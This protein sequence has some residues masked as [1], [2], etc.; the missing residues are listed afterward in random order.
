MN[1]EVATTD[2]FFRHSKAINSLQLSSRYQKH[3][4]KECIRDPAR[5]LELHL[6]IENIP[7]TVYFKASEKTNFPNS[8]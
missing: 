5:D 8:I 4:R 3:Y 2:A 1:I 6:M 7:R